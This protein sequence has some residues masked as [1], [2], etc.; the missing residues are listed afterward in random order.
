MFSYTNTIHI[1]FSWQRAIYKIQQIQIVWITKILVLSGILYIPST[2]VPI[3]ILVQCIMKHIA[4]C[5]SLK[6]GN[7]DYLSFLGS[8]PIRDIVFMRVLWK[9]MMPRSKNW[10]RKFAMVLHLQHVC[11]IIGKMPVMTNHCLSYFWYLLRIEKI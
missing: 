1:V 4:V 5:E 8:G 9:H 2:I 7:K 3:Y 10:W 6:I 11:I